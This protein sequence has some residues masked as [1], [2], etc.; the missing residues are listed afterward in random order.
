MMEILGLA[1]ESGKPVKPVCW[2]VTM[3][4]RWWENL[5]NGS[6]SGSYSESRVA[7][8]HQCQQSER[9]G[10]RAWVSEDTLTP[11]RSINHNN[12]QSQVTPASLLP[13]ATSCKILVLVNSVRKWVLETVVLAFPIYSEKKEKI[14]SF[15]SSNFF[16]A[17]V[18]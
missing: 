6:A 11:S 5:W 9:T 13:S 15:S 16:E 3:T 17:L 18:Y 12:L 4:G 8:G 7:V 14:T 2:C 1:Q 10:H